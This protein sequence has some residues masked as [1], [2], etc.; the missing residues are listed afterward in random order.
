MKVALLFFGQ[1]R[2]VDNQQVIDTYKSSI[3]DKYDTDVFCHMWWSEE[4]GEFDYSSWSKISQCP[5][6]KEALKVVCDNYNPILV[7]YEEP[8]TFELPPNAKKFVDDNFTGKHP[9]GNHWNSKNYS[10]VMSQLYSIKSAANIFESYSQEIGE[11]YDWIVLARY[12]TVLVNFPDLAQCD[13]NKFYLPGHHPRFPDTIHAFGPKFLDWAKN[14][15]DDIDFV[16]ENIWE[17]SPEAFKMGA[18]LRRY[19][20]SDLAPYPMDAHCIRG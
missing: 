6:P 16:Y 9:D 13:P 20:L 11:E 4:G 10:N 5:I 14:A 2:Y 15:F 1:P 17:P 7:G 12:D 3:L 8:K 18:F 19:D